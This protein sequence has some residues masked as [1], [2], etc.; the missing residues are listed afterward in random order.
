[1]CVLERK[2]DTAGM[3]PTEAKSRNVD[4]E[5]RRGGHYFL[6]L[7]PFRRGKTVEEKYAT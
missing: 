7:I 1:V 4:I 2:G 3:V 5:G 6:M